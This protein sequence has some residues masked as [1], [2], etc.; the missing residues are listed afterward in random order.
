MLLNFATM[1]HLTVIWATFILALACIPCM[2]GGET[3]AQ[4]VGTTVQADD[5]H[6][7][8]AQGEEQEL[9]TPLCDCNCCGGIKVTFHAPQLM[10]P[11]H[12]QQGVYL[13]THVQH[14]AVS[15]SF[16]FWHPPRV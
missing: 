1:K 2:D 9:C 13:S 7:D 6:H 5:L 10:E 8:E 14:G 4:S 11:Q 15:P 12:S 3:F 16:P